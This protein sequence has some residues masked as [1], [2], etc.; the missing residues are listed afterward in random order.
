MVNKG[1]K[2]EDKKAG[3]LKRL[4][5]SKDKNEELLNVFNK[6]PKNKVSNKNKQTNK[7]KL[8]YSSQY[9]FAK[10][11]NI[12]EIKELS[13]DSMH[14]ILKNFHKKFTNLKNVTP[15]TEAKK[16]LKNR[17]LNDAGDLYNELYYIYK[18]KYSEEINSL[19]TKDR[20]KF[21][22]KKLR[23]TNDYQYES[24][25]EQEQTSDKKG[26]P[27]KTDVNELNELIIKEKTHINKELFKNY[28]KFQT[29]T[30]MLKSLQKLVD[31]TKNNLLVN[32]VKSGLSDFKNEIKKMSEDEI[33]IEK[34]HK[35]VD[36]V[37]EIL[38]FNEKEQKQGGKGL[39]IFNR[40]SNG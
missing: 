24:E 9:S 31:K 28:F 32:T 34:A 38:E 6:A 16:N 23:L 30:D 25:E 7:Q 10:F 36:I 5:N 13:L 11:K 15:R 18:D 22:Y 35:I 40:K 21:D 14:K 27:I 8:I 12:G 3:N 19:N 4:E 33:K 37:K 20:K 2:E 39:K 17:V 26:P 1:F 29:P